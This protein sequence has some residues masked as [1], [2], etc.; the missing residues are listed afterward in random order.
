MELLPAIFADCRAQ[1]AHKLQHE[2]EIV[3]RGEAVV[4]H[5]FGALEMM[6]ICRGYSSD[7]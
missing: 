7:R 6:Q 1:I 2:I 4:G 5:L 3:D